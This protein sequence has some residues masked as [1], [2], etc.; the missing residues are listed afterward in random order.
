[1]ISY[2]DP[3]LGVGSIATHSCDT[4]LYL[5]GE[6]DRT[7]MDTGAWDGSAP[8]CEGNLCLQEI[9]GSDIISEK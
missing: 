3:T 1:M 6:R 4:G 7:C 9:H 5:N 8:N 2:S